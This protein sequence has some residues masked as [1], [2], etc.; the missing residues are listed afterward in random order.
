MEGKGLVAELRRAAICPACRGHFKDPVILDCDHSYCRACITRYW[1]EAAAARKGQSVF[2]C[3]QCKT[4]FERKNLRTNVKLAVEVKI[5][6][7]L[8]A[9]TAQV[10]LT[11]KSRRRRGGWTPVTKISEEKGCCEDQ[12]N[13]VHSSGLLGGRAGCTWDQR[14]LQMLKW[15]G[16]LQSSVFA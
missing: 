3:P 14:S 15:L 9:K 8:N 12:H 16:S 10:P 13:N 1:E 7:H 6:Q 2:S 11:T 4:V 5:T